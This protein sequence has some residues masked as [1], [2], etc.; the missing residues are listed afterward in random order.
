MIE[1]ENNVS[2][3]RHQQHGTL[4]TLTWENINVFVPEKK[5]GLFSFKNKLKILN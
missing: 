5:P 2:E 4:S 1:N 3:I